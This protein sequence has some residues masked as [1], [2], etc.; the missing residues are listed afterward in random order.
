MSLSFVLGGLSLCRL[1]KSIIQ[2]LLAKFSVLKYAGIIVNISYGQRVSESVD[3]WKPSLIN[4]RKHNSVVK[5]LRLDRNMSN[6]W[7][8]RLFLIKTHNMNVIITNVTC[9]IQ[10]YWDILLL[11]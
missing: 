9:F 7:E 2:F 10:R 11:L 4:R 6:E 8:H 3:G 5:V 1:I